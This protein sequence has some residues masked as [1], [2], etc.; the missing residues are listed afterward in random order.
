VN[1]HTFLTSLLPKR[2][3]K[4]IK[5]VGAEFKLVIAGNHGFE[6]DAS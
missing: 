3:V 6:L 2:A 1:G 5:T 4:D